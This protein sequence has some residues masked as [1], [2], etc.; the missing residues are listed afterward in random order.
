[1]K[2]IILILMLFTSYGLSIGQNGNLSF[3]KIDS[4]TGELHGYATTIT[5]GNDS[6]T[7]W[8]SAVQDDTIPDS[9][10]IANLFIGA[11]TVLGTGTLKLDSSATFTFNNTLGNYDYFGYRAQ[12]IFDTIP[13]IM[14]ITECDTCQA[15]SITGY[16]VRQRETYYGDRML[17]TNYEDYWS[18]IGYLNSERKPFKNIIIWQSV[19]K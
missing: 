19:S 2:K 3:G 11:T 18:I 1:M 4:S 12:K 8:H 5:V 16:F 6:I 10:K 7:I 15:K 14:L 17:P 9:T 13:A